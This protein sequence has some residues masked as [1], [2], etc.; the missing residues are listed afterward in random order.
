MD[1]EIKPGTILIK[2]DALLP[3]QVCFSGVPF[4]R[5]WTLVRDLKASELDREIQ[6]AKWTFLWLAGEVK[7]SVFGMDGPKMLRRAVEAIIAREKSGRFNSVEITQ[8]TFKGSLR[9]PL[10]RYATVCAHWRN[11]QEGL[12]AFRAGDIS[13]SEPQA[14]DL[15]GASA[16]PG[17]R[18]RFRQMT[19]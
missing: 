2:D 6:K 4:V 5:G 10:V 12:I 11:I 9:F 3:E 7:A 18:E 19:A 8:V 1:R 14:R 16:G 13:N 17:S 15:G